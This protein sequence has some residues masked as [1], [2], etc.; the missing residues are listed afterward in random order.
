VIVPP[1]EEDVRAFLVRCVL[2]GDVRDV[3]KLNAARD[4]DQDAE[5]RRA[6]LREAQRRSRRRRG[7]KARKFRNPTRGET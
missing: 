7:I 4:D 6:Y 2:H 1:T 3:R 5:E